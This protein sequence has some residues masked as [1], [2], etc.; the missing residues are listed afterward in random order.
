[1]SLDTFD[2]PA[3]FLIFMTFAIFALAKILAY[4][5]GKAGLTTIQSFFVPGT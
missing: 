3:L 1:V 2:H 4:A 5:S